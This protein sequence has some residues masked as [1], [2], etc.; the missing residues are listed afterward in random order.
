MYEN[1]E[2]EVG[3][4]IMKT[5]EGVALFLKGSDGKSTVA[6]LSMNELYNLY[7]QI[8][9][10]LMDVEVELKEPTKHDTENLEDVPF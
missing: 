9:A 5:T 1:N 7:Y 10:H 2:N 6:N 3:I 8:G 4:A